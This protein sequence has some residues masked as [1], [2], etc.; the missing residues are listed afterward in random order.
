MRTDTEIRAEGFHV[1]NNKNLPYGA[2]STKS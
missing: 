2:N 1:L